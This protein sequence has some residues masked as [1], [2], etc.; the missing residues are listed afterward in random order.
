LQADPIQISVD[1]Q[2]LPTS[3]SSETSRIA[4]VIPAFNEAG[5]VGRVIDA[6][7]RDLVTDIIVV[8]DHSTDTTAKESINNGA[9]HV[10]SCG[11]HGVGAAIKAGYAEG[12][13]QGADVL[14]VLAADGQHDPREIPKIVQPVLDGEADY[15]VGDRLSARPLGCDMSPL[16]FAGNR[17]LTMATRLIT[18]IDVRD[19][20]CGY[21]AVTRTALSIMDLER[22]T[23]SWGVPNDFLV[24]CACCGLRVKYVEIKAR[25]GLRHSYIKIHSYLPRLT[26][27]LARGA[28]RML[29]AEHRT[30][31][32]R[33]DQTD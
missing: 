27:I 13:R 17:I 9:T 28:L 15:V 29:R 19:S 22:I 8:D 24:E 32:A 11:A 23:D 30:R 12:I 4:V 10:T 1:T 16:R 31:M 7:P 33:Q 20:Q 21:T 2:P 6:V 5:R 3:G 14:L 25:A 18:G 26:F